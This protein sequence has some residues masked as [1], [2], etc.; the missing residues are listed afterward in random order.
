MGMESFGETTPAPQE[1]TPAVEGVV[2]EKSA[3]EKGLDDE[4]QLLKYCDEEMQNMQ[5]R[6][7]NYMRSSKD[8]DNIKAGEDFRNAQACLREVKNWKTKIDE[9]NINVERLEAKLNMQ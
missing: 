1:E 6:Y 3:T 4:R 7:E 5:Q 9:H 2:N 8:P